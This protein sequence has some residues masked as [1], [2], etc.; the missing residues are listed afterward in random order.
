MSAAAGRAARHPPPE[1]PPVPSPAPAGGTPPR[2]HRRSLQGLDWL[3]FFVADVQTGFGPFIAV[4]LT[5]RA[6]TQGDIGII[7]SLG[8]LAGIAAQMPGGWVLDAARSKRR[9]LLIGILAIA[10]SALVIALWPEFLSVAIA[11]LLHSLASSV[12]GPG[13]AAISLG[14]VGRAALGERFGRNARY[15]SAGTGVAAGL[16]G[17]TGYLLSSQ[18]VFLVTAALTLPA[19]AAL[20]RIKARDIEAGLATAEPEQRQPGARKAEPMSVLFRQPALL[21]FAGS[22][23]LFQFA[24]AAMLPLIGGFVTKT[25][26]DW[27]TPLI[28]ASIIVPQAIVALVS[29]WIGRRAEAQGRKPLLLLGYAAVALRGLLFSV[30]ASPGLLIAVQLLDGITASVFG[31]VSLL[32]V[33]DLTHDSGRFNLALGLV[34]LASG[35]GAT[36]STTVG[37]LMV[38]HVGESAAFLLLGGLALAAMG[39]AAIGLPETRPAGSPAGPAH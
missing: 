38:D 31:V 5:E 36:L 23:G 26:G 3:C 21:V 1:E 2:V 28:A 27:A 17:A 20:F 13:I 22:A 15:S 4:Y 39:L 35:A 10:T 19:I 34:G 25:S 18:A 8:T 37:G 6:W 16:M 9:L 32:I 11:K 7:L 29:P 33:A 30:T 12:V 24:N 14:L